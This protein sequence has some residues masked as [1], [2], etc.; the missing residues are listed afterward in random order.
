[1]KTYEVAVAAPVPK[2]LTYGQPRGLA[3]E[4]AISPGMRVLVPLGRRKVTGY[5]LGPGED[6]AGNEGGFA[7]KSILELLDPE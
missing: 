7:V 5:V 4:A 3:P 6:Q 2:T 1:M